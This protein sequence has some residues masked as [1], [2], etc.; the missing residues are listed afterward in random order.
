[1]KDKETV[2][3]SKKTPLNIIHDE[4]NDMV[5]VAGQRFTGDFFRKWDLPHPQGRVVFAFCP[6]DIGVVEI[7]QLHRRSVSDVLAFLD[8]GKGSDLS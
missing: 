7:G 8:S 4:T 6:D 2:V 5:I 3:A 1:M